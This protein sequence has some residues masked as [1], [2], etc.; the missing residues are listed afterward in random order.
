[1]MS[2]ER[3]TC[4][5]H[6]LGLAKSATLIIPRPC[7]HAARLPYIAVCP[8]ISNHQLRWLSQHTM[9]TFEHLDDDVLYLILEYVSASSAIVIGY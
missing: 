2:F 5:A 6:E 4:R 3:G 7:M 9:T 1:M 8:G